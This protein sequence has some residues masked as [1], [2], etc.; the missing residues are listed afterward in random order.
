MISRLKKL[1]LPWTLTAPNRAEVTVPGMQV[2]YNFSDFLKVGTNRGGALSSGHVIERT[3][4]CTVSMTDIYVD[5]NGSMVPCCDIR[6]DYEPHKDCVVYQ[7]TPQ[8]SIFD[9]YANSKLVLWRRDLARFGSKG[10]PCNT[11]SR[12]TYPDT[13][14]FQTA[15]KVLSASV[16]NISPSLQG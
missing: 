3:S 7:L 16:D 15:F 11:C 10:S 4:P 8:N 5:Y 1:G 2:S 6:S 9:G 13:A 14:E 12:R